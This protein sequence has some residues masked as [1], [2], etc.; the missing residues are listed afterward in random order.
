MAAG[1]I[2]TGMVLLAAL[3]APASADAG[4]RRRGDRS[5]R[6]EQP[7]AER[8]EGRSEGRDRAVPRSR[9]VQRQRDIDRQRA[10]E[11][12]RQDRDDWRRNNGRG[13]NVNRGRYNSRTVIVPRVISPRIVTVVPYRP[14][15]YR[16][17]LGYNVFY[18]S[19]GLYPYGYT[20]RGYYDPIPGRLYGGLRITDAPHEAQVFA[21]GYYVGI[22]DDFDGVFQH[23][24]LEAGPH[25]IEVRL[26]GYYDAIT[27]DVNIQPGRTI[28]FRADW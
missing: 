5:D 12:Q 22:V 27:F 16:P 25:R 14:Y 4:Q 21:D 2:L 17:R 8:N 26:P 9:D 24:N 1:R 10:E 11:R 23:L 28:T 7:R 18:G 20:P 15:V 19:S 13:P 6:D 3:A